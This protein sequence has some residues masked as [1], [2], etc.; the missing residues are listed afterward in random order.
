MNA[1]DD[2]RIKSLD[3][4]ATYA[5]G[6][7]RDLVCEKEVIRCNNIMQQY[8]FD[9][10]YFVIQENIKEHNPSWPQI[11]SDPYRILIIRG[12][13][14]GKTN[15]LLKLI[16]HKLYTDK[17]YFYSNIHMKQNTNF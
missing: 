4:I 13:G 16:N 15:A 3:S 6:T 11:S 10:I 12:S 2:K 1:N 5:F 14:L 9:L 8:K 17:I 7:S